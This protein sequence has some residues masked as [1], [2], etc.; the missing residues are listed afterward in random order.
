V[1]LVACKTCGLVQRMPPLPERTVAKC[2]RC[3]TVVRKH[4]HNA[5]ERTAA[6]ALAALLFYWPAN[7]YPILRITMYGV[8]SDNT[9]FDGVVSLFQHGQPIIAVIILLAS[10]VVPFLK[11]VGIL[12]LVLSTWWRS[13]RRRRQRTWVYRGLEVI[14]PWAMLDVFLLAILVAL[15]KLG[16]LA[17][18]LPGPGLFA[19]TAVVVL[20]ILATVSF[21]PSMIWE[22][23][24]PRA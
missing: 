13:R 10:I 5:L 24:D 17:T 11:L 14:G 19:F 23:L 7:V 9:V 21:E 4:P 22:P 12:Y 20:T 6:F 18:V 1:S 8:S 2:A 3:G 16:Q 15:V